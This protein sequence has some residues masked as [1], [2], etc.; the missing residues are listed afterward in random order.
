M[1]SIIGL[2]FVGLTTALGFAK[3]GF[4]TNGFDIDQQRI[5]ELKHLQIPF[6]EPHLKRILKDTIGKTLFINPPFEQAIKDS[7]AIFLCVGTPSNRDGSADLSYL[8]QAIKEIVSVDASNYRVIVN[9]STVPPSTLS[10]KIYPFLLEETKTRDLK[11]GLASNPEFLREGFCWEDFIEPD[12][13]VIGVEDSDA[14]QILSEIYGPFNAPIHYVTYNT[15]EY[16]KYLSNTLL[17]TMISYANEMS[18]LADH[19]GDIDIPQ[20][21]KILHGDKRWSGNPANMASYVFPGCGY[22]GYCLPKDTSAMVS[23][24]R[25]NGFEPEILCANLETNQKIRQYA[26]GKVTAAVNQSTPI[27]ILGLSFKPDSDDVR[28]TP[29]RDI[30]QGLIG[31]GYTNLFAYDPIANKAFRKGYPDLNIQY[32]KTLELLL[33]KVDVVLILTG[34]QEFKENKTS[35]QKKRVFD[36]RYIFP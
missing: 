21:F 1:I 4:K 30:I 10:Q 5:A 29:S 17:S 2:G 3:K 24:A 6:H 19:I 11:I 33:S 8:L 28:A 9:K 15:A 12:R 22:G 16:I 27:G 20:A 13:I 32:C 26:V 7:K 35:I 34:W 25:Q 36:L 14:K 18:M 23:I 31:K